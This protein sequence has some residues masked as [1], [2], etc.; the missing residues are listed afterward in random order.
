MDITSQVPDAVLESQNLEFFIPASQLSFSG[1]SYLPLSSQF[2]H[3][4]MRIP[5]HITIQ[6]S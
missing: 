3:L 2:S 5:L 1:A 6:D 4:Q